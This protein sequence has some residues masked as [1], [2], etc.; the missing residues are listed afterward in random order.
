MF[1][2]AFI[3]WKNSIIKI[4]IN[5][6]IKPKLV[7]VYGAFCHVLIARHKVWIGRWIY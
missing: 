5:M 7:D 4:G 6:L 3:I 1:T 2:A